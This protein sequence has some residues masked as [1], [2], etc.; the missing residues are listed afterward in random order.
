[1]S[2]K[3]NINYKGLVIN[4]AYFNI[5]SIGGTKEN[6]IIELYCYATEDLYNKDKSNNTTENKLYADTSLNFAP[7]ISD[8]AEN[9]IKQGYKS[10]ALLD[11]FPDKVDVLETGQAI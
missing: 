8:S 5:H 11:K 4:Q 1:M 7:D 2:F 10:Q 6:T 9:W 3:A